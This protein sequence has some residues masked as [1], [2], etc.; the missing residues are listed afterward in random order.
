MS[1]WISVATR[2]PEEEYNTFESYLARY[3][4]LNG[5]SFTRSSFLRF[6][7]SKNAEIFNKKH[8]A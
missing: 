1:K 5:T 4:E 8:P 3:N 2:I 7:M 6:L